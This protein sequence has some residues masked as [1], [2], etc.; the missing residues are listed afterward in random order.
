MSSFQTTPLAIALLK[1]HLPC[2]DLLLGVVSDVDFPDDQGA[3]LLMKQLVDD[4]TESS[5]EKIKFLV[6][7]K[8]ANPNKQ[9]M[10]HC[11]SVCIMLISL[12]LFIFDTLLSVGFVYF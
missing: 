2:A 9:D 6:Q 7:K 8:G 5:V 4:L 12:F 1:D 10:K 11:I 3:T